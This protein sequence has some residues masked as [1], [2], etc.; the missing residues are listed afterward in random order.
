MSFL[1]APNFGRSNLHGLY[2]APKRSPSIVAT[3]NTN[4]VD[5]KT[6]QPVLGIT[7]SLALSNTF[8][9]VWGNSENTYRTNNSRTRRKLVSNFPLQALIAQL[10][11]S[12]LGFLLLLALDD[13][14]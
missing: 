5:Y 8:G 9:T 14:T 12:L 1:A 3:R 7:N 4:L 2:S 11:Y 10:G 6:V 13:G